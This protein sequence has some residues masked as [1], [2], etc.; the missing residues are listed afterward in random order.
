MSK[1]ERLTEAIDTLARQCVADVIESNTDAT[2]LGW[3]SYPE[4]GEQDWEA[5]VDRVRQVAKSI[6]P[7]IFQRNAAYEFLSARSEGQEA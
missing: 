1:D 3:E 7:S 2:E 4:V 6:Q 5:I